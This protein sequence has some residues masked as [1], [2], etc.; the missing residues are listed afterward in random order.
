MN[1]TNTVKVEW[2][3]GEPRK[4]RLLEEISFMDS[5]GKMWTAPAGSIIDG[6]SIPKFFW[7]LIGSPFV[8]K[9][10]EAS[11]IHD[12]YCQTKSA[13]HADVH[14]MFHEAMRC[15]GVSKKKA[16]VMY[17]AVVTGGPKWGKYGYVDTDEHDHI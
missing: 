8:G 1:F 6:A 14:N 5:N 17:L 7:R 16:L 9:F 10:R 13:P 4:M 15:N 3:K 2:I 12:V 11:V